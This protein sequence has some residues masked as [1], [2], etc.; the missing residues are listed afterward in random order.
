MDSLAR[1]QGGQ[2]ANLSSP[3]A[4]FM[5]VPWQSQINAMLDHILKMY[6]S[7]LVERTNERR[8]YAQ[9]YLLCLV[10]LPTLDSP[11]STS[12]LHGRREYAGPG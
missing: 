2:V 3:S 4:T 9:R 6:R 7:G 12:G 5:V 10:G 8:R 11:H 1:L